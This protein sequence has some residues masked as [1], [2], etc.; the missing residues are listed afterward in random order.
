MQSAEIDNEAILQDIL[1][2]YMKQVKMHADF[3]SYF[4]IIDMEHS[5]RTPNIKWNQQ[6]IFE[7][8]TP[9]YLQVIIWTSI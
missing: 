5:L 2:A 8:L 4:S 6:V 9:W 7:Q 3:Q 1:I